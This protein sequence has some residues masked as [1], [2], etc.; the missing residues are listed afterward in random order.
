MRPLLLQAIFHRRQPLTQLHRPSLLPPPPLPHPTP[1]LQ[2]P[3]PPFCLIHH[4]PPPSPKPPFQSTCFHQ[5]HRPPPC[6]RSISPKGAASYG[7]H[8][9][10]W[11]ASRGS[12]SPVDN[13]HL[14]WFEPR[15]SIAYHL[16]SH[17]SII[18]IHRHIF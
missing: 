15:I 4:Q 9:S 7:F 16:A 6:L 1:H 12:S 2:S 5:I 11:S 18:A 17:P 14:W 3:P 10:G 13:P 8:I